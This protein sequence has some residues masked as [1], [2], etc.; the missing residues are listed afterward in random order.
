MKLEFVKIFLY[1]G[2][3]PIVL[4]DTEIITKYFETKIKFCN[5]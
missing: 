1:Y 5:E 2:H 4:E 3:I